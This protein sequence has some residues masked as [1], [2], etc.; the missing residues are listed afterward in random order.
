[1]VLT[2]NKAQFQSKNGTT[3]NHTAPNTALHGSPEMTEKNGGPL[4]RSWMLPTGNHWGI[5][6]FYSGDIK[7]ILKES[8]KGS[9]TEEY[10]S[11][12]REYEPPCDSGEIP[13]GQ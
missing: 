5:I 10:E 9:I 2:L 7:S 8:G 11:I 4:A 1:M 13:C 6:W 3:R 12:S